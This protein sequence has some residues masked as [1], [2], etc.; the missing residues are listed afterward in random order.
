MTQ[1][2]TKSSLSRL[3]NEAV[4]S[5]VE[6]AL[7]LQKLEKQ[8]EIEQAKQVRLEDEI[9]ATVG[10]GKERD[11]EPLT[12]EKEADEPALDAP[13]RATLDL[14]GREPQTD[15]APAQASQPDQP[16]SKK[17]DAKEIDAAAII[18]KFNIIRSGRSMNDRDI[19]SAMSK[20]VNSLRPEQRSAMFSVLAK[21]GS[22]VAP[23]ADASRLTK[24]PEEP[25][26]IQAAR[27]QMLQKRR[28][29]SE[30]AAKNRVATA[31]PQVSPEPPPE[32]TPEA[33]EDEEP[34][35]LSPPIR[36]GKRTAE[37]ISAKMKHLLQD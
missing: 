3:L 24:P 11:R 5:S 4:V 26:A 35:D 31:A 37:S 1:R 32:S 14:P 18:D 36:V 25:S 8:A 27:V 19:S 12:P 23:Q 16:Q 29:D 2:L 21:I 17:P 33:P 20:F 10:A 15:A 28:E 22:I 7:E 13:Q 9:S 30:T 6:K 34:E